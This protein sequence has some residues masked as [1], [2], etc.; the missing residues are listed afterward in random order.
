MD[1]L[2]EER[3]LL[4]L[5]QMYYEKDMTQSE[6]AKEL[7]INRS[8]ISRMLKKVRDKGIVTTVIN[9]DMFDTFTVEEQ[10]KERFQ[11]KDAIVVPVGE[12]H[13]KETKLLAM[14][15]AC[16]NYLNQIVQNKDVIGF[17][18]GT[19]LG[20]AVE[21]LE[22]TSKK[23]ILCVPMIGGPSGKLESKYHVNTI[24]FKAAEKFNAQSLMID[25]PAI[26]DNR[27]TRNQ[28]LKS[29]YFEEISTV[30]NLVTVAVF[31]I[32]SMEIS[33]ERIWKAFYGNAV[34]EEFKRDN[35]VG[36]ICS[37][38]F[39]INGDVVKTSVTD[40]TINIGLDKIRN[41]RY[42]IGVA[43]SKEK[44]NGII[45]ALNSDLMKVLVT[46]EETAKLILEKSS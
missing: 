28:I 2:E 17:S 29:G 39:D 10:L 24:C 30:W 5:A 42:S 7:D 13:S 44:V 20:K 31:G 43:E 22:T 18:W 15:Q 40:R 4:K 8:T 11:L 12:E 16:A 21:Q 26:L 45:G 41:A 25:L 1:N 36:D 34:T 32:G 6:I 14:G 23:D 46:T 19:G 35:V 38:F 9:Y 3:T 27:E 37:H 33:G